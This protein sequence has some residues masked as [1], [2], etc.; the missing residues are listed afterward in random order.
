[1]GKKKEIN[2][3]NE[4]KNFIEDKVKV[5]INS[6][7]SKTSKIDR[8]KKKENNNVL[9]KKRKRSIDIKNDKTNSQSKEDTKSL[10]TN[11]KNEADINNEDE[12]CTIENKKS[13][14]KTSGIEKIVEKNK[15]EK[16]TK[17]KKALG[18]LKRKKVIVK[19]GNFFDNMTK[20]TI[21]KI[22]EIEIDSNKSPF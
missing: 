1:M 21:L 3:D 7:S 14:V 12:N 9:S 16:E 11:V 20:E 15:Q 10:E 8:K 19:K 22:K 18:K 17:I 6:K 5:G 2:L 13:W 4:Q